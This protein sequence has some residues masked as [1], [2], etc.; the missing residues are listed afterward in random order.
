MLEWQKFQSRVS[1]FWFTYFFNG[2]LKCIYVQSPV[3]VYPLRCMCISYLKSFRP[4]AFHF[5]LRWSVCL[6]CTWTTRTWL[7][8]SENC[9]WKNTKK[10][11]QQK[12]SLSGYIKDY[13]GCIPFLLLKSESENLRSQISKCI[14]TLI[15]G[16]RTEAL[17]IPK[18]PQRKMFNS[19]QIKYCGEEKTQK[20]FICTVVFLMPTVSVLCLCSRDRIFCNYYHRQINCCRELSGFVLYGCSVQV[21]GELYGERLNSKGFLET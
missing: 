12:V 11:I 3:C 14:L 4:L 13:Q 20:F 21:Q 8:Q 6:C 7:W 5:P 2:W 15:N 18:T 1:Q 19:K 10:Y 17:S 9:K 16:S